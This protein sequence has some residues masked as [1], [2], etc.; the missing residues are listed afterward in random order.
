MKTIIQKEKF[1]FILPRMICGMQTGRLYVC[2][3]KIH[4]Y[5][6]LYK[7]YIYTKYPVLKN[8]R[9]CPDLFLKTFPLTFCLCTHNSNNDIRNNFGSK[10]VS[11]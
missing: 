1:F 8:I 3:K 10:F 4:S 9:F 5:V 11:T 2:F 6:S 7:M